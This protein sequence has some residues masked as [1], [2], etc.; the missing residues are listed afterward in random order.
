MV[1][2]YNAK[3]CA[4]AIVKILE[5]HG[6]THVF[7]VPGAK[8]DSLFIALKHSNI[9]LVLCRHEQNAAFMAAAFG[10]LTG[11]IGVCLATS[12]PGITNLTTGLATATSEGDPVL[13]I[14]G[15]VPLDERLKK[16]HQSLDAVDLMKAVTKYSA[17]VVTAHQLGEIIGNAIRVAESGRPGAV[18]VSLPKDIGLSDFDGDATASWGKK[19]L[20]GPGNPTAMAE[21][22]EALHASKRPIVILGM[23]SSSNTCSEALIE[24]LKK[25]QIPYISTFQGAG[26]WVE[27]QGASIYG[28]RI[29]LFRN[30]PTDKL[31][32]QA[33]LVI[34]IGYD[35][36]EYD[37]ALWN[38]NNTRPI[39]CIDTI[40]ADQDNS[41]IPTAE[42][43]G[44]LGHVLMQ[45]SDAVRLSLAPDY[46]ETAKHA[47]RE[48]QSTMDE[49]KAMDGFPVQPLRLVHELQ[50]HMTDDTH[51]ALD[52]GS[53]YIWTN[54]YCVTHHARQVLVSNGQQ[55]LGVSVPWAIA[56]S[57]LYPEQRVLSVSGDGGFLFSSMELETA[58]R[59]GAKFVHVI[60]DSCSYDMVAFQEM[61]HY[62]ESAGVKLGSYDVVNMAE[63]FGCKGYSIKS[64]D[65]LPHVFEEAFK[66]EVPVLIHVP[67]D[68]SLN[69]R[70]MEDIH[71]SFIN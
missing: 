51:V 24:F 52:V 4:A 38:A 40:R 13:A 71:Q 16:T 62:G 27:K 54:R 34:T 5:N 25:T 9:K 67:V 66:A 53:N 64:A 30:Q 59:V 65:E 43:I 10:R 19:L 14:G 42:L 23:Q 45:L 63:S 21:A 3:N 57:L 69:E 48:V 55:T 70:L 47:F 1:Q 60:W 37:P 11:T 2:P 22:A 18:F 39:I 12:G 32:D 15:E 61:A 36:I 7:G 49:G 46:I 68:Y 58:V 20:Q 28:G 17:E 31:L 56:L 35:P 33:D 26:A 29:G 41:F 44:D 50:K 8:I 6:V